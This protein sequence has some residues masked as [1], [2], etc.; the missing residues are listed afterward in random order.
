MLSLVN[1]SDQFFYLQILYKYLTLRSIIVCMLLM[2]KQAFKLQD[3]LVNL[4]KIKWI[5]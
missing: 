3:G 4:L 5:L 2:M 1:W